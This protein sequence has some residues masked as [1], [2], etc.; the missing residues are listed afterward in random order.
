MSRSF[1]I[2]GK[3]AQAGPLTIPCQGHQL[4]AH[5]MQ[6]R[7]RKP[8]LATNLPLPPEE[9]QHVGQRLRE[10]AKQWRAVMDARKAESETLSPMDLKIRLR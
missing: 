10:E 1:V 3:H 9:E 4:E 5:S 6:D 2:A 7:T 8:K